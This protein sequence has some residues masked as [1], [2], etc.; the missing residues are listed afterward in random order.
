MVSPGTIRIAKKTITETPSNVGRIT[1]KRYKIYLSIVSLEEISRF[2]FYGGNNNYKQYRSQKFDYLG[3]RSG[4]G[5]P[6]PVAR[7]LERRT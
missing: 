7:H 5:I 6:S 1:N 2:F 4:D 3:R